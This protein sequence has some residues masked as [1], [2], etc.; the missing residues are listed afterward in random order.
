MTPFPPEVLFA[1]VYNRPVFQMG[2][3][4][5]AAL[6][7]NLELVRSREA[8]AADWPAA[9]GPEGAYTVT[10]SGREAIVL[11]LEDLGLAG[12]DE[13]MIITTSG[14]PYISA[15]VTEMIERTC[16]WSRTLG[17]RTRAL[18]LIHEFGF[19]AVLPPAA[20]ASGLPVIEDCA[21]GLGTTG[22]DGPA[23]RRGDYV[24]W[25]FSKA[26]PIPYGG[27]LRSPRPIVGRSGL[28]EQA[29]RE[30]PIL[31]GHY[32][33]GA[34]AAFAR[35]RDVFEL[36]RARFAAEGLAPLFDPAPGVT[37]HSFVVAMD[38]QQRAEAMK[39]KLQ[40][41]GVISSVFYGGGGYFLPN[42][43]GLSEAAVDYIAAQFMA[44][45]S[46]GVS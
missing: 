40:A 33:A 38:D 19:P 23:G 16:R 26:F 45:Y 7:R 8:T 29:R 22:P 25:S 42:H 27:L 10:A 5:A 24:V 11:A 9:F 17:P 43:Q 36:Y 32:L 1:D 2:P 4:D 46:G 37:P 34:E 14:G 31:A 13:V 41:A 18:F 6:A 21:Y 12:D 15:C 35:R 30:L 39:P 20:A 3:F 28:S 44:A